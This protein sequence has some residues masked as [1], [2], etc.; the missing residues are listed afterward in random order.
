MTSDSLTTK[1]YSEQ[2]TL[3]LLTPTMQNSSLFSSMLIVHERGQSPSLTSHYSNA[4]CLI[5]V[6]TRYAGLY[7]FSNGKTITL[8]TPCCYI[9][10]QHQGRK[11]TELS[12]F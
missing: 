7:F 9:S 12:S 2:I 3:E 8:L 11:S 1:L 5:L 10:R 6:L 4:S